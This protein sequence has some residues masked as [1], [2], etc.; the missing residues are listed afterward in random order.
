[1]QY[2][3]RFYLILKVFFCGLQ[4]PVTHISKIASLIK[5]NFGK[6]EDSEEV[7][8]MKQYYNNTLAHI[9]YSQGWFQCRIEFNVYDRATSGVELKPV[10]VC[11]SYLLLLVL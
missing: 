6:I 3:I 1:M 10:L 9:S 8:Q 11:A 7:S 5:Q 2:S 4:L